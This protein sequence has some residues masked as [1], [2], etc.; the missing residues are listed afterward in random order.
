MRQKV[1]KTGNN[2]IFMENETRESGT[3]L[4]LSIYKRSL[5]VQRA[6]AAA[7]LLVMLG[8]AAILGTIDDKVDSALTQQRKQTAGGSVAGMGFG[9]TLVGGLAAAQRKHD[10]DTVQG[11]YDEKQASATPYQPEPYQGDTPG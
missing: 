1:Y 6:I 9:I 7:G 8:G 4:L 10:A 2:T 5:N 3:P 11:W